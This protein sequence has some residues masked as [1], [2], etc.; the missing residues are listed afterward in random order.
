MIINW[1]NQESY[2]GPRPKTEGKNW[3]D[4]AWQEHWES[5]TKSERENLR[6]AQSHCV[7]SLAT[8]ITQM[9]EKYNASV[10]ITIRFPNGSQQTKYHLASGGG[11]PYSKSEDGQQ[12][13]QLW[14]NHFSIVQSNFESFLYS[15]RYF[16]NI[17]FFYF[18]KKNCFFKK[19]KTWRYH[20]GKIQQ[21]K[22][23]KDTGEADGQI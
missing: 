14:E 1:C 9:E 20:K 12:V 21:D 19:S 8:K 3:D 10:N 18:R 23:W 11:I 13:K 7:E 22:S 17:Y 2:K 16:L 5:L 6:R 4:V 15:N